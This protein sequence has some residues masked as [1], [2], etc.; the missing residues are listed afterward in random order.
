MKATNHARG[1][2][3]PPPTKEQIAALAYAIWQDRGCPEGA[4]IDCWF[5]AERELKGECAPA[6][7]GTRDHIPADPTNFDR[8]PAVDGPSIE[9]ELD[10]VVARREPRS[11]T[12]L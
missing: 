4:D 1:R 11:P 2:V 3:L 10:A 5:E 7:N 12:A 8:D 9:A 6:T